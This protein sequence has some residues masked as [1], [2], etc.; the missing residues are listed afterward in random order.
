[1]V[2]SGIIKARHIQMQN[3]VMESCA[4]GGFCLGLHDGDIVAAE[5]PMAL[6]S[7][8][9]CPEGQWRPSTGTVAQGDENP[10][11]FCH[12]TELTRF[13]STS[14]P[15]ST[16]NIRGCT[17]ARLV[18]SGT[19]GQLGEVVPDF[20]VAAATHEALGTPTGTLNLTRKIWTHASTERGL[21]Q[22][23]IE[24]KTALQYHFQRLKSSCK[25]LPG[26]HLSS[27]LP[28]LSFSPFLHHPF[29]SF[30]PCGL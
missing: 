2:C 28:L 9:L 23:S 11:P 7:L 17:K 22:G 12:P 1:M 4:V 25:D 14:R 19:E 30:H 29:C 24:R 16:C 8:G 27:L 20:G 10:V 5:E 6:S 3:S 21:Q 13:H 15:R 26:F 18:V